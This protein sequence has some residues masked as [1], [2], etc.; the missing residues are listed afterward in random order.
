[1]P[2]GAGVGGIGGDNLAGLNVGLLVPAVCYVWIGA[3][4]WLA[5]SGRLERAAA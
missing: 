4:G 2:E 5:A 1:M 3:Y